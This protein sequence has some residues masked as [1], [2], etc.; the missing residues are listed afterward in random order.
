MSIYVATIVLKY[1]QRLF[2]KNTRNAILEAAFN[3]IKSQSNDPWN[4]FLNHLLQIT[5][6]SNSDLEQTNIADKFKG[7]RETLYTAQWKKETTHA[8]SNK[9][10]IYN[11]FKFNYKFEKYLDIIKNRKYRTA[12]TK[13][14]I[15]ANRLPS[16]TRSA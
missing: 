12:L 8:G 1:H 2:G 14:R 16:E 3:H 13:F 6:I 9:L 5:Q 11:T 15:S 10:C 7:K 4:V